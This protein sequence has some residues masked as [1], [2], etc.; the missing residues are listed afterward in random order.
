MGKTLPENSSCYFVAVVRTVGTSDDRYLQNTSDCQYTTTNRESHRCNHRQHGWTTYRSFRKSAGHQYGNHHR[1]GRKVLYW[2]SQRSYP[3]VFIYRLQNCHNGSDRQ[4]TPYH[5][6]GRFKATG[7]SSSC[8]LWFTKES[9]RY[10]ICK[11]G[12]C[13]RPGVAPRT[14][15]VTGTARSY[16]GTEYVRGQ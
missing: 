1:L 3:R 14:E 16:S 15:C 7:W 13:G 9:K 4:G 8:G 12:Q 5:H 6:A 10:R 11:Y 2:H